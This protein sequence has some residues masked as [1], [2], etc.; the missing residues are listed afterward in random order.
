MNDLRRMEVKH[1]GLLR[2]GDRRLSLR[3]IRFD[4]REA[5]SPPGIDFKSYQLKEV[6]IFSYYNLHSPFVN[7]TFEGVISQPPYLFT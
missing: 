3:G 4:G 7:K 5:H 1:K 6:Q 2:Y